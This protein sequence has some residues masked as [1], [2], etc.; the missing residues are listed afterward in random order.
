MEQIGHLQWTLGIILIISWFFK[1]PLS[2]WDI[3]ILGWM[4]HFPDLVD[5]LWGK[6]GFTIHHRYV[7]HSIFFVLFWAILGYITGIRVIWLIALGSS[8]HIAED[9][10]AGGGYI[11]LLSP[12]TRNYGKVMLVSR[13]NQIT[14]GKIV[15]SRLSK[16]VLGTESLPD[17]LAFF[18]LITMMGTAFFITGVGLYLL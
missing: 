10:L 6:R 2:G 14:L 12:L 8:F 13:E 5:L 1:I 18:W 4:A 3:F 15:K 11:N 16:Y 17:D 9:I 7:T